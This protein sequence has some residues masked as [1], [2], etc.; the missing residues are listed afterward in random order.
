MRVQAKL[1]DSA[2]LVKWGNDNLNSPSRMSLEARLLH[3]YRNAVYRR[4]FF[5]IPLTGPQRVRREYA[6]VKLDGSARMHSFVDIGRPG[7]CH[8]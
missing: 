2:A 6:E 1:P 3:G 7:G 8:V 5:C 4:T